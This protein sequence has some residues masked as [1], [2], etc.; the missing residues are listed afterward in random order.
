M[1]LPVAV[2]MIL[3]TRFILEAS[4]NRQE[5]AVFARGSAVSAATAGSTLIRDCDFDRQDFAA[6]GDVRQSPEVRCARRDAERGLSRED[7]VW[8][9]MEDAA[10]PWDEILR[11]VRPRQGP[12]DF[13]ATANATLT[14][15]GAGFLASQDPAAG[16]DRALAPERA[17]WT[18][19]EGRFDEGHDRVIWDELCKSG[20]HWLFP[21]VFPNGG[22]PRC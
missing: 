12:R 6:D 1:V 9:A 17:F 18:H 8:D 15:E 20:A 21:N 13:V 14:F 22:G 10:R 4:V 5:V 7:P 19:G 2:A 11:D 3:L 16:R